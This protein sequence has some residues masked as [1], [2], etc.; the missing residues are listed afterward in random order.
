MRKIELWEKKLVWAVSGFLGL[1]IIV[2]GITTSFSGYFI[3]TFDEY[4]VLAVIVAIFPIAVVEYLDYR[5][6][7]SID[8]HLPDFFRTIVQIRRT[9]ATLPQAIEEAS[10]RDFGPLTKELRKMVIQMSWGLPFEEALELFGKRVNTLLVQRIVPLIIEASRSGG[11]VEKIFSLLG[12][13]VRSTILMEKEKR[14]RTRPYIA[15]TYVAFYVFLFTIVLLFKSF[16]VN[17]EGVPI[18][19]SA[20]MMPEETRRIFFHMGVFQAFF[21]GLIAGKMGEGSIMAGLKHSLI[22]LISVYLTFK[23][24]L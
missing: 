7:K 2:V 5:W 24:F 10:K 6:R 19:S 12:R 8:Q 23:I 18:L 22:L 3:K 20:M 1:F 16:F 14:A 4:I 15:I 11:K 9:G 13:F 21:S 17:I